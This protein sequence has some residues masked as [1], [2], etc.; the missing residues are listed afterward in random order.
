MMTRSSLRPVERVTDAE[1]S[2]S[3][4]RFTPSGVSSN[5]Q[6]TSSVTGKPSNSTITKMRSAQS[7]A[8]KTGNSHVGHLYQQ[9]GDHGVG[10]AHAEYVAAL[11][12][13]KQGHRAMIARIVRDVAGNLPLSGGGTRPSPS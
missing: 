3:F 11:E 10:R 13:G 4:S 9:P 1:R 5:T 12:F 2:M 6:A 7:G 8:P